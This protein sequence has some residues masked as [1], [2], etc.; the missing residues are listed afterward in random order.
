MTDWSARASWLQG[1][2]VL[3][4]CEV[5]K[6]RQVDRWT[7][8][9]QS[10]L[11]TSIF[12]DSGFFCSHLSTSTTLPWGYLPAVLKFF[13]FLLAGWGWGNSGQTRTQ[14]TQGHSPSLAAPSPFL[15]SVPQRAGPR[16]KV[17]WA[18]SPES[19]QDKTFIAASCLP[20]TLEPVPVLY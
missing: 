5:A 7:G 11:H 4:W 3:F 15:A 6:K 16:T 18:P 20:S 17:P 19:D 9:G 14:H 10:S 12:G 2:G 8:K 13:P 1:L